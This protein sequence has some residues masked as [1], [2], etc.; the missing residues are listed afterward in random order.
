MDDIFCTFVI[1]NWVLCSSLFSV[2]VWLTGLF[3]G[4]M[5]HQHKVIGVTGGVLAAGAAAGLLGQLQ[6]VGRAE[7]WRGQHVFRESL[8]V[9]Q[10]LQHKGG[11]KCWITLSWVGAFKLQCPSPGSCSYL[12]WCIDTYRRRHVTAG[13]RAATRA[14]WYQA[15][16]WGHW[17]RACWQK[18]KR[19]S[20]SVQ[21]HPTCEIC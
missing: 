10:W 6:I 11:G 16:T 3:P 19:K 12:W 18:R 17:Y 4:Q 9:W 2:V 20:F 1:V 15:W 13:W 14:V 8:H 21:M 5:W 7:R